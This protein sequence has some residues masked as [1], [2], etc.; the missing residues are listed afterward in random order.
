MGVETPYSTAH[1]CGSQQGISAECR[2]ASSP[3]PELPVSQHSPAA[4]KQ[5]AVGSL[6][7]PKFF[8]LH[9]LCLLYYPDP[10]IMKGDQKKNNRKYGDRIIKTEI[11]LPNELFH[12]AEKYAAEHGLSRNELYTTAI[13]TYLEK[14]RKRKTDRGDITRAIN[15]ICEASEIPLDPLI[16][17]ASRKVLSE[18]EW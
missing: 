7:R 8:P 11:S 12:I 4:S 9:A 13:R 18:S 6:L 10:M 16:H 17:A 14:K 5:I 1:L 3:S 2:I 15:R